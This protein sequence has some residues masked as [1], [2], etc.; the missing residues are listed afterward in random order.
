[1]SASIIFIFQLLF[2]RSAYWIQKLLMMH[3]LFSPKNSQIKNYFFAIVIFTEIWKN[4]FLMHFTFFFLRI[5]IAIYKKGEK[6][7]LT[8]LRN[9]CGWKNK[10]QNTL[11]N[12]SVL[13]WTACYW[14][15]ID[16]YCFQHIFVNVCDNYPKKTYFPIRHFVIFF[17]VFTAIKICFDNI[18]SD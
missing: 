16:C 10:H 14:N 7:L 3:S 9:I 2:H 17:Y 13:V 5:Y 11:I 8:F 15:L 18:L 1:M 6:K 4:S 12:A